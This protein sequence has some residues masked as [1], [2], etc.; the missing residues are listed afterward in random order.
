MDKKIILLVD[1]VKLFLQLEESFLNRKHY[2]TVTARTGK[3]AIETA[4]DKLPD[5][6]MLDFVM[7]DMN[8]DEVCRALKKDP[9]TARIPV[10]VISSDG[11][12]EA[13]E[14][15]VAAGCDDFIT[16][17]LKR[18]TFLKAIEN[19]LNVTE[20]EYH[21]IDTDLPCGVRRDDE[22]ING[23][24]KNISEVGANLIL[25]SAVEEGGEV[26]FAFSLPGQNESFDLPAVVRW[27]E[28]PGPGKSYTAGIRY[29]SPPPHVIRSIRSYIQSRQD[30]E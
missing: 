16:K 20:R 12:V 26:Q 19:Q 7:P 9:L 23:Q 13:R 25:D 6:I 5:I 17:P 29:I 2:A 27:M 21:R 22:V 3:E 10:V 14:R 11:M 28:N 1:D 4:R 18:S 30:S 15:C 8:G 24:M